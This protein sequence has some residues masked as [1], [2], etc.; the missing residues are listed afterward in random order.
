MSKGMA[1]KKQGGNLELSGHAGST[2]LNAF[3]L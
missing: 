3:N 1:I 2:E